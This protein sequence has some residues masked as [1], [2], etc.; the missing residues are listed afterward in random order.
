VDVHGL[1]WEQQRELI[2]LQLDAH[3]AKKLLARLASD[4][5]LRGITQNPFFLTGVIALAKGGL[6]IPSSRFNLLKEVIQLY[7]SQEGRK[8]AL[9]GPPLKGFCR[10]YL[11]GLAEAMNANAVTL[12]G[13]TEA[14]RA[15]VDVGKSLAT[16]KQLLD[17]PEPTDVIPELCNRHLLQLSEDGAS[18]RFTHQRIQE[19]F[20]AAA[21]VRKLPKLQVDVSA[22]SDFVVQIMNCPFWE[23]AIVLAAGSFANNPALTVYRALLVE[24]ALSVDLAFAC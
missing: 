18:L 16:D 11:E 20:S 12:L 13:Q 9:A 2:G 19:F 10:F 6:N 4:H 17:A 15:I 24:L 7:E 21:L 5:R 3:S 14:R 22:R 23:D 1:D 8:A